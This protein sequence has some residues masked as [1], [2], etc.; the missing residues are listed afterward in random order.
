MK[1]ADH[2]AELAKP[3]P[4]PAL[5]SLTIKQHE[6]CKRPTNLL[7]RALKHT[8]SR[9]CQLPASLARQLPPPIL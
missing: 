3:A 1:L 8:S 6:E 9:P 5:H 4:K 7:V 2:L